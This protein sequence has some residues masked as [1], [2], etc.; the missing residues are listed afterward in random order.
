M[1]GGSKNRGG[2]GAREDP[3]RS[4]RG[5]QGESEQRIEVFAKIQKNQRG[6]WG[7]EVR[8]HWGVRVDVN[9]EVFVKIQQKKSGGQ[10]WVMVDLNIEV[11]VKIQKKIGKGVRLRGG[12]GVQGGCER[13]SEVIV[14]IQKKNRAGGGGR[15]DHV[16]GGQGGCERRIEVIVKMQK[17]K[18]GWVRSGRGWGWSRGG[19]GW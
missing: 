3:V 12:G 14:K 5:G 1:S 19:V 13:R 9:E 8:G 16:G 18:S 17:K 4:V 7:R 10:G 2:G 6:G 11:F 15:E